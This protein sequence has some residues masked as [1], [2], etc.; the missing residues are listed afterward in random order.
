MNRRQLRSAPSM[1]SILDDVRLTAAPVLNLF[2]SV[3][4]FSRLKKRERERERE[5]LDLL[6]KIIYLNVKT[7]RACILANLAACI[8]HKSPEQTLPL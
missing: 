8:C 6:I 5:F 2:L 4:F 1:T 3:T 7:E